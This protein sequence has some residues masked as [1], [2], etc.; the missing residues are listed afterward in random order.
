MRYCTT[1]R[2]TPGIAGSAWNLYNASS[3]FD[4]DQTGVGHNPYSYDTYN[5]IYN[6]YRV[7]GSKISVVFCPNGS[8]STGNMVCGIAIKDDT[9]VETNFDSI[10]EAK[11]ARYRIATGS[12]RT[13]VTQYYSPKKMFPAGLNNLNALFGSNPAESAYFQVFLTSA[14]MGLAPSTTDCVVTIDYRVL[15]W[16]LKDLGQS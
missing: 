2:L 14:N 16:E 13:V 15:V 1:V 10:R 9:T 8:S 12:E 5:T 3:I 11:G 7:I 6:H 4:P